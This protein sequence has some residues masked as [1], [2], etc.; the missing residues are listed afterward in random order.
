MAHRLTTN[1][2]AA[3]TE[4][5]ELAKAVVA[6]HPMEMTGQIVVVLNALVHDANHLLHLLDDEIGTAA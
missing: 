1:D 5:A 2:I 6:R 3:L 4:S